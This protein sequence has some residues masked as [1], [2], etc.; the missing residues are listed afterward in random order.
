MTNTPRFPIDDKNTNAETALGTSLF[1]SKN[2]WIRRVIGSG[3]RLGRVF[4]EILVAYTPDEYPWKVPA[5]RV[6]ASATQGITPITQV[7]ST[8]PTVTVH[9]SPSTLSG[10]SSNFGAGQYQV[11]DTTIFDHIGGQWVANG[12]SNYHPIGMTGNV[13]NGAKKTTA[14][15]G[16]RFRYNGPAFDFVSHTSNSRYIVYVTDV[17]TGLRQRIAADDLDTHATLFSTFVKIDFGTARDRIIEV[18]TPASGNDPNFGRPIQTA[19]RGFNA[20]PGYSF[21]KPPVN[22]RELKIV[23]VGDSH[24]NHQAS[25]GYTK[26]AKLT[27]LDFFAERLGVAPIWAQG[28][29]GTGFLN[30]AAGGTSGTY[31]QRIEAGD[32]ST[33]FIGEQ[34]IVLI[35]GTT[36]DGVAL[37]ASYTD[38]A[39]Q[40]EVRLTVLAAMAAQPS[41]LIIV[42]GPFN[43]TIAPTATVQNVPQSRYDAIKAGVMAAANG[44]KRVIFIDNSP[45]GTPWITDANVTQVLGGGDGTHLISTGMP[46]IGYALGDAVITAM[47]A[48]K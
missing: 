11:S 35:A 26:Q 31:R 48:I 47:H 28:S 19:F 41:A 38:A 30:P 17:L 15:A 42:S 2:S 21:T 12:T 24:V 33:A 44:A 32:L 43:R 20:S 46:I 3:G 8:V 7:M 13:T 40:E 10:A 5:N 45:A 22:V 27:Y 18:Y 34:D 16:V 23:A 29:G 39:I 6:L 37:S 1:Y 25:G 14:G 36:N 4:E 9:T